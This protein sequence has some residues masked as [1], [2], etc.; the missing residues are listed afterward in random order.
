MVCFLQLLITTFVSNIDESAHDEVNCGVVFLHILDKIHILKK[1][2]TGLKSMFTI[3]IIRNISNGNNLDEDFPN[4]TPGEQIY[5][6]CIIIVCHCDIY[7]VFLVKLR[8]YKKYNIQTQ[9]MHLMDK[10]YLV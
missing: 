8:I 4:I 9:I 2:N 7:G 10:S 3:N 6:T 5:N 1:V